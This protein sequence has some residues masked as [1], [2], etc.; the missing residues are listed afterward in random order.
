MVQISCGEAGKTMDL[1]EL[2]RGAPRWLVLDED[3]SVQE[4]PQGSVRSGHSGDVMSTSEDFRS[5]GVS[6][7]R[8][9]RQGSSA[10]AV[11]GQSAAD[12]VSQGH[13]GDAWNGRDRSGFD[14]APRDATN[15][16]RRGQCSGV[17]STIA[18]SGRS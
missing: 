2:G 18:T 5:G 17:R 4:L 3:G 16:C 9:R 10:S 1:A 15:T 6:R 14:S 13:G 12:L 8:Q 7:G 11:G